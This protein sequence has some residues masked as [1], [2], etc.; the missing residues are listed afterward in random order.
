MVP[1]R[2]S[3]HAGFTL[4]E[5]LV[6]TGII[7][8][9]MTVVIVAVNPFRMFLAAQQTKRSSDVTTIGKSLDMYLISAKGVFPT[10][11]Y[12]LNT[13]KPIA[14]NSGGPEADLCGLLSTHIAGLPI[15]P[16]SPGNI[17]KDCTSTYSTGYSAVANS[18][19]KIGVYSPTGISLANASGMNVIPYGQVGEDFIALAPPVMSY[20]S[21]TFTP[22]IA[23]RTP[24]AGPFAAGVMVQGDWTGPN[25]DMLTFDKGS[26]ISGGFYQNMDLSQGSFVFWVTPEWNG[27][28]GKE[29]YFYNDQS[30][31][32]RILK[33]PANTLDFYWPNSSGQLAS[34]N[35]SSWTA[36]TTYSV[37]VRWDSSKPIANISGINYYVAVTING[38]STFSKT[39]AWTPPTGTSPYVGSA[40]TVNEANALIQGLTIY[41]RPLYEATTPSGINVGNGDE[42]TQ[43]YNGGTGRDPTLVTG[44]WDVVFALPTNSTVGALGTTGE[45][46]SHPHASNLLYTSTTNTGGYMM[47]GTYTSDGWAAESPIQTLTL[48]P[49]STAGIDTFIDQANPTTNFGTTSPLQSRGPY[50]TSQRNMLF[51]FDLSSI[52][53]AS[54]IKSGALTLWVDTNQGA[55]D[56]LTMYRIMPANAGWTESGANWNTLDG[57]TAWA[58]SVGANTSGVDYSSTLMGTGPFGLGNGGQYSFSLA[59]SEIQLMF[60]TNNGFIV[61]GNGPTGDSDPARSSD[62]GTAGNRPKLVVNYTDPANNPTVAAL[63]AGER[64]FSGGYKVTSTMANQGISY[65]KALT[66]N[67]NYVIRA[68]GNSDG[69]CSP[70]ILVTRADGSTEITHLNGTAT[71]TR[72]APDT[73]IFTFQA[74]ATENGIFKLI[75]TSGTGTCSWHQVEVQTNRVI[76]PSLESGA[77]SPWIPT[78]WSNGG[79]VAGEGLQENTIVHS[80]SSALKSVNV[81]GFHGENMAFTGSASNFADLGWFGYRTGGCYHNNSI[82]ETT[83]GSPYSESWWILGGSYVLNEHVIRGAPSATVA[84]SSCSTGTAYTDDMFLVNLSDVTLTLTPASL[85]NSTEASGVRV[86][87]Y[88]TYTQTVNSISSTAGDISFVFTPRHSFGVAD[89]YGSSTPTIASLWYDGNNRILLQKNATSN[90]VLKGFFNGTQVSTNWASAVL[91]AGTAYT[92]RMTYLAGGSLVLYVNGVQVATQLGVIPFASV[93]TTFA[94][95]YNYDGSS[96]AWYDGT[97]T[98][99]P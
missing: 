39:S 73:Y 49:D 14:K 29:H 63:G 57:S 68:I 83:S 93:P 92:I 37:M 36:G 26:Q 53:V 95:G 20:G 89:K 99:V 77:G 8:V 11:M 4:I 48:Q 97:Y 16:N 76:N 5:L 91:N 15:D 18:S 12:P 58:G 82:L 62:Y 52:P 88:D 65:T 69:T 80:G 13:P 50:F 66:A 30:Q 17:V 21:A 74:P 1:Y 51:K 61:K 24:P 46:W 40:L 47:N 90:L 7:A 54:T 23:K 31:G 85:A 2:S 75:N 94:I 32:A 98:A 56:N 35:I 27:N 84:R 96:S 41:R 64:I 28:D 81:T 3:S 87:G 86:D 42:L 60:A 33:V 72:T 9:L 59:A 19:G 22:A 71:S 44:S 43:I 70:Q 79:Y 67:A 34:V 45:A 25:G 38:T 6:A 78:G 10:Q 55:E